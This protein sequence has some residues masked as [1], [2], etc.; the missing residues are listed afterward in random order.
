[1]ENA[2]TPTSVSFLLLG[3]SAMLLLAARTLWSHD[4]RAGSVRGES[5]RP[6]AI[7][8]RAWTCESAAVL[9]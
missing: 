2:K 1:M 5:A 9:D 8:H 7:A 4:E 3:A 6:A